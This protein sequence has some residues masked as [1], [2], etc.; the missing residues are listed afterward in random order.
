MSIKNQFMLRIF[1]EVFRILLILSLLVA[2]GCKQDHNAIL[3]KVAQIASDHPEEALDSLKKIEYSKLSDSDR[4][5]YDFLEIKALD[6]ANIYSKSDSL[7]LDVIAYVENNRSIIPYEEAL[8]YGGRV[9]RELGDLPTA[10]KYFEMAIAEFPEIAHD[11]E[12]LPTIHFQ[13][14]HVFNKL[15]LFDEA[16]A[17]FLKALELDSLYSDSINQIYDLKALS[18]VS[19][20]TEKDDD[21]EHFI[22]LAKKLVNKSDTILYNQLKINLAEVKQASGKIPEALE[23]VRGTVDKVGPIGRNN[24]LSI[25]SMVYMNANI[26]DTAYKYA[27]E[28]IRGNRQLNKKIG[29]Y[30]L[31]SPKLRDVVASDS[32]EKFFVEYRDILNEDYDANEAEATILQHSL[33]NYQLHEREREKAER[34]KKNLKNWMIGLL[35]AFLIL[36]IVFLIYRNRNKNNIIKLHVALET[37]RSLEKQLSDLPRVTRDKTTAGA[38]VRSELEGKVN[39]LED[40]RQKLK[41]ELLNLNRSLENRKMAVNP[42][43]L[44]SEAYKKLRN[45]IENGVCLKEDDKLWAELHS[46]VLKYS[47]D[48]EKN[49]RILTGG[50]VSSYDVKTVILIKFNLTTV[51]MAAIFNRTNTTIF[52][53]RNSLSKRIF[54]ETLPSHDLDNILR[55][56]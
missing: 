20:R 33:Y 9:Y 10:L 22:N 56:L 5:Y 18:N 27:Y 28:L 8:Y 21:A 1:S 30:V 48:F 26:P 45:H 15:R 2:A 54:G 55:L 41:G 29:Y 12:L 37:V 13:T 7:I 51:Q 49:L 3:E 17:H 4:H 16:K 35:F 42:E 38:E 19:V 36:T 52:S 23:L 34:S 46:E 25:S 39:K 11:P 14:G 47:G 31:T 32:L 43:L 50:K 40:L 53:R 6:K 24:A 44:E